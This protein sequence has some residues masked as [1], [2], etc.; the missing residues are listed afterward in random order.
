MQKLR[1]IMI[2]VLIGAAVFAFVTLWLHAV[3][4][5]A[6]A[7]S[8]AVGIAVL[9]VVGTRTDSHDE[10][11]DA[12]WLAAAQDLPPASDRRALEESQR[13]MPGPEPGP[14]SA[15]GASGVPS[16]DLLDPGA[17]I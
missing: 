9:L 3:P 15:A 2:A 6:I 5:A 11:A 16:G 7:I 12:A 1:G 14:R 13:S 17:G 4:E 10:A 8:S